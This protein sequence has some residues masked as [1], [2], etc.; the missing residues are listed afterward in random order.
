VTESSERMQGL[1]NRDRSLPSITSRYHLAERGPV[2]GGLHVVFPQKTGTPTAVSIVL[3]QV[4]M[5]MCTTYCPSQ[6][7]AVFENW[8]IVA[9]R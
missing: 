3:L 2:V 4:M 1:E 8:S 9:R 5:L 6:S 7:E